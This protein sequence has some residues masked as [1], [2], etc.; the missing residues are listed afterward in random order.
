[1]ARSYGSLCGVVLRS[2][3]PRE[4]KITLAVMVSMLDDIESPTLDRTREDV[5]YS[6]GYRD[7][8]PASRAIDELVRLGLVR[9]TPGGFELEFEAIDG[10]GRLDGWGRVPKT[11]VPKTHAHTKMVRAYQNST[12]QNGTQPRAKMAR[13]ESKNGTPYSLY[14]P[15]SDPLSDPPPPPTPPGQDE[16]ELLTFKPELP[17]LGPELLTFP[18]DDTPPPTDDDLALWGLSLI[19]I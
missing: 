7:R 18:G 5:A 15:L 3:L 2:G 13:D 14:G 16:D 1:M 4:E 10:L 19:H 9:L 6:V 17:T 8:R 12:C 11:H